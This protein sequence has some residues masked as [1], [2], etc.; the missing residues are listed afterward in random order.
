MLRVRTR[1]C[2][3][4]F[5]GSIFFLG[6]L[7][8]CLW[9]CRDLA[10]QQVIGPIILSRIYNCA[11]YGNRPIAN[12]ATACTFYAALLNFTIVIVIVISKFLKRYSKAKRYQGTS[13][14]TSAELIHER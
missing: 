9:S 11:K 7:V 12:A 5:I 13:S 4:V 8:V 14:F 1:L 2:R 6:K 3:H 10:Y